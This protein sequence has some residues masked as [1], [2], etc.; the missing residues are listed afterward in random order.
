MTWQLN[1][2]VKELVKRY[3]LEE[4]MEHIII[5]LPGKNGGSRRCFILKRSFMRLQYPDGHIAD[6]PLEEVIEA[7]V[8]YPEMELSE[9]LDILHR[10][11]D[12]QINRMFE[13]EKETN[14]GMNEKKDTD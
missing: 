14:G 10:E 3:D 13:Q 12:A 5:P 2:E 6:Y 8:R 1:E 9:S 4:D 11:L 7:I